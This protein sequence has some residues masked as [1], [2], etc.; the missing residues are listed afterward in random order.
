MF[1]NIYALLV[2]FAFAS[3]ATLA[4]GQ[5]AQVQGRVSDSTGAVIPK[6]AVRVIDLRTNTERKARTNN[7]GEYIVTGL[8]PSLYKIFVDAV[9]FSSAVSRSLTLNV[10]Q[11]AVLDFELHIGGKSETVTVNGSSAAI[12]TTD[13]TVSTV[14][15]RQFVENI[16]L[17]GRSFQSLILLSPGTVTATPQGSD[18]SG[19]FSVNGQRTDSNSFNMDGASAMNSP[20]SGQGSTSANT[21]STSSATTL[22]TTQAIVS[23]D[24]LQEF[25][26]S[27]ST[28]SAEFGR[29]AGAQVSF[30]SRSGT[31]DYHGTAFDYV[32][33]YAFD[34]NNWFNTYAATPLPKPQER[35]NDFGGTVGGP[36]SIPYLISG[37]DRAFFFF[38]YE[39]LRLNQP[40]AA[41]IKYVPTNGTFNTAT[42]SDARWK[43]LRANAAEVLKPILNGFPL[44]NC[45][46]QQDAQC[47]DYGDGL[48]PALITTT[49]PSTIDSLSARVDFQ[50]WTWMRVFARYSDTES[51]SAGVN[52]GTS[53][54]VTVQRTRTYLLGVDSVL[55]NFI[56]NE[57]RLQYSPSYYAFTST[58]QPVEGSVPV[59]GQQSPNIQTMQGL[60]PAGGLTEFQ[61]YFPKETSITIRPLLYY[62]NDGTRQ[63]QPN[64]V[65]TVTWAHGKHL[66]K[67]GANYRQTT[68]YF[69][70]GALSASPE[71]FN[72]IDSAANVLNGIEDSVSVIT[73]SRE[74]PIA[75]NLGL[76]FQDEWRITPRI[77][78]SSGL[79]W[80]LNPP[81]EVSGAQQYTYTGYVTNPSS[82]Q[83]APLGTPLYKTTYTDF[84]PRFG[85]A[86]TLFN[87]PGH[88]TVLRGGVGLFYDTGQSVFNGTLGGLGTGNHLALSKTKFPTPASTILQPTIKPIPPYTLSWVIDPHFVPPSTIQ[89]S[90]TLEQAFGS[91]QTLSIGYVGTQG[92]NLTAYLEYDL[93]P[94]NPNFSYIEQYQ[95]GGSS[96]YNALQLQYNRQMAHGLQVLASYT[97]AHAIDTASTAENG[98]GPGYLDE[99]QRGNSDHDVRHNFT[100]ALV[101]N[102]PTHYSNL[103]ERAVLGNWSADL[104]FVARTAFPVQLLGTTFFDPA[105][106]DVLS[107]R[108][109]WNGK[110]PY[111]HQTGIP[112]GK[113][114]N[115]AV[116]SAPTTAQL[117]IGNSPRNFLRGFG[118]NE[119]DVAIQ[120]VFPI[121]KQ[122]HLQFRA[123]AFNVFNHPNFGALNVTC[124]AT[125]AGQACNNPIMGQATGT[126]SS[127]SLGGLSSLY[128]HGGPRSL[129]FELKLQF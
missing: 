107:T 103:W 27:T 75:K 30:T 77:S 14:V 6:A 36:L 26:I 108:L 15:D 7:A 91:A 59:T 43:N 122:S 10:D 60:P 69:G 57:L 86:T 21:G 116:F 23:V 95:N 49:T 38:S 89:W 90:A 54:D 70:D 111:I 45:S 50:P 62:A 52:Y 34:A 109:N 126:L 8:N 72:Y 47:I 94:S 51:S 66:F 110:N 46:I 48:S 17:N 79:R 92:R 105:T 84:G 78:L 53:T 32:R 41:M 123:E 114:F 101:Y 22:G 117:G 16:P 104:W 67:A 2:F 129:Q 29:G 106:G 1:R 56:S 61:L 115:P 119:S 112:G 64:A 118:E 13:G 12:N 125:V 20:N 113:Q 33:N 35:Q 19:E 40:S 5:S 42:Y 127:A 4:Y 98:I 58:G 44:P 74:D 102:L 128:Q 11:N 39:G 83:L 3:F 87:R 96:S 85:I 37:K 121:Y 31:N 9:G 68:T 80:D 82:V 55:H 63:F 88:E 124:G 18:T 71:I 100:T 24:A 97:W 76:F 73:Y 99:I 120:R 93:A 65:D 25:R 28:Y 81:V